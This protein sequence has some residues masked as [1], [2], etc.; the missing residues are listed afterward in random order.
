MSALEKTAVFEK[1][2]G[3][4]LWLTPLA[5]FLGLC[6]I[7][8]LLTAGGELIVF[9]PWPVLAALVLLLPFGWV[10]EKRKTWVKWGLLLWLGLLALIFWLFQAQL[11]AQFYA[12]FQ[13][14]VRGVDSALD[15]TGAVCFFTAALLWLLGV[16]LWARQIWLVWILVTA[17]LVDPP[18]L[19]RSLPWGTVFCLVFFQA[20]FA[21]LAYGRRK[22][23][24]RKV[25]LQGKSGSAAVQKSSLSV[26]V[27]MLAVLLAGLLVVN[28]FGQPLYQATGYLQ[29]QIAQ[30]QQMALPF[31]PNSTV[32]S[33]GIINRGNLIISGV[34][35]MTA[36]TDRRPTETLYLK[37]FTG[38]DYQEGVWE[39]AEESRLFQ[40]VEQQM[41]EGWNGRGSSA[42]RT[43]Y[44]DLNQW[45][46]PENDALS[47]SL[48]LLGS[49][50]RDNSW[51]PPYYYDYDTTYQQQEGYRFSYYQC[52]D[53]DI[54]WDDMEVQRYTAEG[55]RRLQAYYQQQALSVYTQ[56]PE[57]TVPRLTQL[58]RDNPQDDLNSII[59]FVREALAS[60][61]RYTTS[62]GQIP[63]NQDPVEYALFE[64]G[65]GYCQ[66][67]ASAAVLMFRLYG[68]PAR[69][70][71]GYALSPSN[72]EEQ[73]NGEYVASV[74]DAS[75]HAW[76]EIF[77]EDYGWVPIE[78]TFG[79]SFNALPAEEETPSQTTSSL[80]SQTSSSTQI[81]QELSALSS[82][83]VLEDETFDPPQEQESSSLPAWFW[84]VLGGVLTVLLLAVALLAWRAVRLR[85]LKV[86]LSPAHGKSFQRWE[87]LRRMGLPLPDWVGMAGQDVRSEWSRMLRVLRFGGYWKE[88]KEP[89]EEY[90]RR[91]P[92]IN[93]FL[94]P[95]EM[96]RVM[97]IVGQAAY[98]TTP[99]NGQ[100]AKQVQQ[101]YLRTARGVYQKLPWYRKIWFKWF[102]VAL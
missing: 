57:D 2:T 24:R 97:D 85:R 25:V 22:S 8:C 66:H 11:T 27:L 5:L 82:P 101:A 50:G 74:T 64:N 30:I 4:W 26:G 23:R 92:Q 88:E 102:W 79:G 59:A 34:E 49:Y 69:Y 37:G 90:L 36:Y 20:A 78:V 19:G 89:A 12:L 40:A 44:Y 62:P 14:V 18:L 39:E 93:P 56:V 53:I 42:F 98:G 16:L 31:A 60:R 17:L 15:V 9:W 32:I 10:L 3:L 43:M 84:W 95:E 91:H 70:V 21:A 41:G 63:Y 13:G 61:I 86:R 100:Q 55:Y 45:S 94:S 35:Q 38:G 96:L 54:Q 81:Q 68:I 28:L 29:Y 73:E 6:G 1:K 77:L 58:C 80:T 67:F 33:S 51:Y 76:P 83:S 87:K 72:F 47:R 75:A 65:K 7:W 71:S 99:V 48:T 52:S 46:E